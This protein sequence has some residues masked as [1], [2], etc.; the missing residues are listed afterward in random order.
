MSSAWIEERDGKYI[1]RWRE[2]GDR[3]K[4]SKTV[5]TESDARRFRTELEHQM[6]SGLYTPVA[7]RAQLFGD[8][9]EDLLASDL[10]LEASSKY[11]HL[12]AFRKW[13]EPGLGDTPVGEIDATRV[14]RFFAWM[15]EEGASD[16]TVGRIRAQ[17]TKYFRRA[18]QE[19]ILVRNPVAAIPAPKTERRDIRV[20]T[21]EEVS[22][23]ADAHPDQYRMVPL[24]MAWGTFRIGE[25]GALREDA[26]DGDRITVLRAIGTAGG[27]YYVKGPKTAASRR[28]VQLPAWVMAEL[29][30]H[31]LRYRHDDGYLFRA[32]RGGLLTHLTYHN[33]WR[34]ALRDVSFAEPWPRP[35]DLRHT[36][37][38]IMIRAGAD[39]KQIQ[40]RCGHATITETFDTYGH[41]FPGHDAELL[42]A[43][44]A[45]RPAPAATVTDL[46]TQRSPRG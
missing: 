34:A 23:I 36:A 31:M 22:G 25:V 39:P 40:A 7:A 2:P 10:R 43:L 18:V 3:T 6:N 17:L 28:T 19:G 9:V 12:K 1:V 37:V 44:E 5:R 45:F 29:R 24:L 42:R 32:P 41:L 27:T 33:V 26:I 30:E 35:H 11:N 8:Y 13:I 38:A 16:N 15:R 46:Q 21:P 20:L 14:R 4:H